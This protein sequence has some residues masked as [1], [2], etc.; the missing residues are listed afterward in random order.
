MTPG[1]P[2]NGKLLA[3]RS[4]FITTGYVT[5]ATFGISFRQRRRPK[6]PDGSTTDPGKAWRFYVLSPHTSR[7]IKV[8]WG[9]FEG[10]PRAGRR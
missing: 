4:R 8:S 5:F 2:L 3:Y 10:Q 6:A 1:D 7:E 9:V